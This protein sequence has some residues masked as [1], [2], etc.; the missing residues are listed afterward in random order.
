MMI[1]FLHLWAILCKYIFSLDFSHFDCQYFI[2]V[3]N[4]SPG[5]LFSTQTSFVNLV[6]PLKIYALVLF[7]GSLWETNESMPAKPLTETGTQLVL[8]KWH[9]HQ[10][11]TFHMIYWRDLVCFSKCHML[12][13]FFLTSV[14]YSV[15]FITFAVSNR[16]Q[17]WF[18]RVQVFNA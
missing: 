13:F 17:T 10:L 6:K 11:L 1:S 9:H 14:S 15:Q 3:K 8:N 18:S 12:L 2:A 16:I 7:S 4:V 5:I